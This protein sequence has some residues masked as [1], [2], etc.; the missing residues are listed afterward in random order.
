MN[1]LRTSPLHSV[2]TV[3]SAPLQSSMVSTNTAM[4]SSA[5]T[6]GD[7]PDIS[8]LG[9]TD[10]P[11]SDGQGAAPPGL[12]TIP[13]NSQGL[14]PAAVRNLPRFPRGGVPPAGLPA[15]TVISE[16]HTGTC[17]GQMWVQ[18]GASAT[19]RQKCQLSEIWTKQLNSRSSTMLVMSMAHQSDD[20][21]IGMSW[22]SL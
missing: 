14:A 19:W 9:L 5:T 22:N 6:G 17:G 16:I 21:H 3:A 10:T 2:A 1:E 8:E 20:F 4:S 13:E 11:M 15:G 7:I 12:Q 18:N